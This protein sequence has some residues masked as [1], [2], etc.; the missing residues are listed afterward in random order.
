[1]EKKIKSYIAILRIA[2]NRAVF[3]EFSTTKE[4]LS[5][6][7]EDYR[8]WA[9]QNFLFVFQVYHSLLVIKCSPSA[10]H[11]QCSNLMLGTS[12]PVN[13][14][15]FESHHN[16]IQTRHIIWMSCEE[17]IN[18]PLTL[19]S[20]GIFWWYF[21]S[22]Q[23]HNEPLF[24]VSL[25]KVAY[26]SVMNLESSGKFTHQLQ[27]TCKPGRFG[28]SSFWLG[29]FWKNLI[30]SIIWYKCDMVNIT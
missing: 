11:S 10:I 27:L 22:I 1:M 16:N 9:Y 24:E 14:I 29:F 5:S 17:R 7:T 20:N 23:V 26:W 3:F 30:N 12:L 15:N 6:S 4:V 8:T 19:W 21:C 25:R 18:L 28:T 2:K 13:I